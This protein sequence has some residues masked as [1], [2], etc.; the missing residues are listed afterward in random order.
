MNSEHF[1]SIEARMHALIRM[2]LR[3]LQFRF[4][5][6]RSLYLYTLNL[7][8]IIALFENSIIHAIFIFSYLY[9]PRFIVVSI[10]TI[11]SL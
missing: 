1:R 8:F 9:S 3:L 10:Q 6:L 2:Q 7:I 11:Y 4:I 5:V